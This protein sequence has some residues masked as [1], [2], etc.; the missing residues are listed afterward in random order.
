MIDSPLN[1][2]TN[3]EIENT[4]NNVLTLIKELIEIELNKR[5]NLK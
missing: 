5:G 1:Y 2:I 3:I 4:N